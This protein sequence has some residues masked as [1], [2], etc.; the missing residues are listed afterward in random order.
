MRERE[1]C[2]GRHGEKERRERGRMERMKRQ[3]KVSCH[4]Q[5]HGNKQ[6]SPEKERELRG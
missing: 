2:E 4:A 3:S 6:R 5:T 1:K